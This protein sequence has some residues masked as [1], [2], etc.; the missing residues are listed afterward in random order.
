MLVISVSNEQNPSKSALLWL[1]GKFAGLL[2]CPLLT[3]IHSNYNP[4]RV[5]YVDT[6]AWAC[7]VL[8]QL[9]ILPSTRQELQPGLLL[10][11]RLV[12]NISEERLSY[13]KVFVAPYFMPFQ[14]SIFTF[15]TFSGEPF[16]SPFF[17]CFPLFLN[18]FPRLAWHVPQQ[19]NSKIIS[20]AVILR[21]WYF[22]FEFFN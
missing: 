2:E 8:L 10:A 5:L 11:Q 3:Y 18:V 22:Y 21:V 9:I 12:A 15:W 16:S 17:E 19:N 4:H 20:K 6:I 1:F 7:I 13:G 14:H